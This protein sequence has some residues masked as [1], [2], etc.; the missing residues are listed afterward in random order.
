LDDVLRL[1]GF[2]RR[3]WRWVRRRREFIDVFEIAW[4]FEASVLARAYIE[5][6]ILIPDVYR[7]RFASTTFRFPPIT[8]TTMRAFAHQLDGEVRLASG[9]CFDD[10]S[11]PE[12]T[13]RSAENAVA[14]GISVLDKLE[15]PAAL[16]QDW[17]T[18][19]RAFPLKPD[20]VTLAILSS[21]Q[22]DDATARELLWQERRYHG[23]RRI[24]SRV[25]ERLGYQFAGESLARIR[26]GDWA[27]EERVARE[28]LKA[29]ETRRATDSPELLDL[30]HLLA[31]ACSEQGND[32]D[33]EVIA[34]RGIAILNRESSADVRR[35]ALER[36]LSEIHVRQ[37]RW[38]EAEPIAERALDNRDGELARLQ[39][40]MMGPLVHDLVNVYWQQGKL[41]RVQELIEWYLHRIEVASFSSGP[42]DGPRTRTPPPWGSQHRFHDDAP[43]TGRPRPDIQS[44]EL[45]MRLLQAYAGRNNFEA[46]MWLYRDACTVYRDQISSLRSQPAPV[47]AGLL[48]WFDSLRDVL[49]ESV[50]LFDAWGK[51]AEARE[52]WESVQAVDAELRNEIFGHEVHP[53]LSAQRD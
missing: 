29:H 45:V 19:W 22:G 21:L 25:A 27:M 47:A 10:Q 37:A 33:A 9:F 49:A 14:N 44:A 6:G 12:A 4:S 5:L 52:Q 18:Q 24:A 15:S 42:S 17:L 28:L 46:A 1:A 53:D 30:I 35:G 11:D 43:L 40:R 26:L 16:P 36:V 41:D 23:G 20:F 34:S 7:I 13:I 48:S 51:G 50:E 3:Q 39:P 32:G 2:R 38:A 31:H 8:R